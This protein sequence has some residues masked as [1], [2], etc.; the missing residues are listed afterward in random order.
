M[1]RRKRVNLF[2]TLLLQF[3]YMFPLARIHNM[4][5]EASEV[6]Y[7]IGSITLLVITGLLAFLVYEIYLTLKALQSIVSQAHNISDNL[8]S[9]SSGIQFGFWALLSKLFREIT[10]GGDKHGR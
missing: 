2:L 3:T 9:V 5:M 4:F 1:R 8:K 10:G 7:V 6:F